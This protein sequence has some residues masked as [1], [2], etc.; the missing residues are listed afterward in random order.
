VSSFISD[1]V[2]AFSMAADQIRQVREFHPPI[3]PRGG[4]YDAVVFAVTP[5]SSALG[6]STR[7][8]ILSPTDGDRFF[9]LDTLRTPSDV[10]RSIV[11][12]GGCILN[13][14]E[15]VSFAG[16][17]RHRFLLDHVGGPAA[18]V[19]LTTI[20]SS[21]RNTFV[22]DSCLAALHPLRR[23]NS[24]GYSAR[25]S[26][27]ELAIKFHVD[28]MVLF[29]SS[30]PSVANLHHLVLC[31]QHGSTPSFGAVFAALG[32]HRGM[33][34]EIDNWTGET[35]LTAAA[36][37]ASTPCLSSVVQV[38]NR[39][40]DLGNQ[41]GFSPL[42]LAAFHGHESALLQLIAAGADVNRRGPHGITPLHAAVL[43][44]N[45]RC[46]GPL[47]RNGADVTAVDDEGMSV[48][49]VAEF[50]SS[51]EMYPLLLALNQQSSSWSTDK[52]DQRQSSHSLHLRSMSRHIRALECYLWDVKR[53]CPSLSGT[54]AAPHPWVSSEVEN[55]R[56]PVRHDALEQVSEAVD[57]VHSVMGFLVADI[58][59]FIRAMLLKP[60]D[61]L[62]FGDWNAPIHMQ[63]L[64][65]LADGTLHDAWCALRENPPIH[66]KLPNEW[67]EGVTKLHHALLCTHRIAALARFRESTGKRFFELHP[68]GMKLW[69][70]ATLPHTNAEMLFTTMNQ[71][72]EALRSH[73]VLIAQDQKLA[74]G[75]RHLLDPH[76]SGFTTAFE[77]DTVGDI[78]DDFSSNGIN[79]F[80]YLLKSCPAVQLNSI[81]ELCAI[82][83]ECFP[84]RDSSQNVVVSI[85]PTSV[86]IH[87]YSL[88]GYRCF[89]F[90]TV[91]ELVDRMSDLIP[92]RLPNQ[93][94]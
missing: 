48:I 92:T 54:T 40:L 7:C 35:P 47:M 13:P 37:S 38:A 49:M 10:V 59:L 61:L 25:W 76:R 90:R 22:V 74:D 11:E 52:A 4:R 93:L 36:S 12:C 44:P 75:V 16:F 71:L 87:H 27:M 91:V 65:R 21:V 58:S 26:C 42:I 88:K 68:H 29:L 60:H 41:D 34:G 55:L 2:V 94:Y 19:P 53:Y 85:G 57:R 51:R 5:V 63:H 6:T 78:L 17:C 39:A 31:A 50:F 43:G 86:R 30:I 81:D 83:L 14:D 32:S 1:R 72:M 82:D 8:L 73:S 77:F 28:S 80:Q 79:T 64:L 84:R 56:I 9:H 23:E 18:N 62:R 33:I 67:V 89:G 45:E 15:A 24:M 70:Q 66:H 3:E 20:F 69:K 46:V